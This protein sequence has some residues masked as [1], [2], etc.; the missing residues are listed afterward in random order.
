MA[1]LGETSGGGLG[2]SEWNTGNR[3]QRH[4]GSGGWAQ[5]RFSGLKHGD[6]KERDVALPDRP[7]GKRGSPGVGVATLKKGGMRRARL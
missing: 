7:Y 6:S 4:S 5:V 3:E 2:Y 1:V